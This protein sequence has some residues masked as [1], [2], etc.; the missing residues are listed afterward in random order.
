MKY[1]SLILALA[2]L[3]PVMASA[4]GY[5]MSVIGVPDA[6]AGSLDYDAAT[7]SWTLTCELNDGQLHFPAVRLNTLT[8]P[9][10]AEFTSLCFDYRTT[11]DQASVDLIA[12]KV[13][14]GS[15][16]RVENFPIP[17]VADGEWHTFRADIGEFR[18]Q[19]SFRFLNK[20]GQ[21]QDLRFLALP[22]GGA[23]Q[24]RNIRYDVNEFPFKEITINPGEESIIEAEDFNLAANGKGHSFRHSQLPPM[25]TYY[26][27]PTGPYFPIYAWGSVDFEGGKGA[28]APNFL[29]EQY[30]EL[31]E[32]GFTMTMGTAWPGVDAAF[33][34]D[35]LSINGVQVNLHEG[36]EL[37]MIVKAALGNE[38]EVA[39][40]V[41]SASDRVAGWHIF[42][43]PHRKDFPEMAR[44]VGWVRAVD[45]ERLCYGNL[46]N[47]TTNMAAIGFNN[48]DAYVHTY[49]KEVGTGFLSYDFY[50]V[51]QYINSG[52][53]YIEPD[54][55][56]NLEIVSKLSKYYHTKFWAFAHSVASNCG[57]PG[58]KYPVPEENHMRV[59]VFGNLAYGAQGLQYFTYKCPRPYG[60]Y[61]YTDAPIDID[62][63]RTPVWYM[64]QRINRDIHALTWVFLGAEMLRVG[65]TNAVTPSGC[66]RLSA[67]MLPAGVTSV[68]HGDG[69][70][71][72]CVSMLQ[73]GN[74]LFMM[75][76]N[77]DIH[78]SQTARIET[79]AAMKRVLIDGTT[80][81][82]AAGRQDYEL[83]PGH[84]A[85]FLVSENE[86]EIE[87]LVPARYETSTYRVDAPEVFITA[88]ENASSGHYIAAM[89]DPSWDSY[90]GI[91]PSSGSRIITREQAV[92]NWGSR[93]NY[94]IEVS[95]DVA[96]D[97]SVKYAV[98]FA[99]YSRVASEGLAPGFSYQIED[100]P[101]LNWPKQYAASMILEID[102]VAVS[103]AQDSSGG[104]VLYLGT[105]NSDD[106]GMTPV[107]SDEPEYRNVLLR[108][109]SHRLTVT[110][111]CYPWNFDALRIS[112]TAY[113]GLDFMATD[114]L[115]D[116]P[117]YNLMGIE[118][119]GKLLPGIY[120]RAGKKIIVR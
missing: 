64:V 42:D 70:P 92:D 20:A 93:F 107:Y 67:D 16:T 40:R 104:N 41:V 22:T 111:L 43:E 100:N 61:T 105:R 76:L 30:K 112:P 99:E 102:S 35:G 15:A 47:I 96:V 50:P 63:N 57:K 4:G 94:N 21:F 26:R 24:L 73:N 9:V 91:I 8:E 56:E 27:H 44:K 10:P 59:Q 6:A 25:H 13:F 17:L 34:H 1:K 77:G 84:F 5:S 71:G 28:E 74:N 52:E 82:L 29:H 101:T 97:I 119:R 79:S 62:N 69:N 46:L 11:H 12:Y 78:Q 118:M 31:W 120:V 53:I 116:A 3:A 37:K 83:L 95:A 48:Y 32:C 72:L 54:F 18:T 55:F 117:V 38:S 110:S 108:A 33:I 65:H 85:L 98:P 58:V 51:R 36:T 39:D 88:S 80:E 45:Q 86:P 14:L 66:T 115:T 81:A 90:S 49:M 23:V 103:P 109:G 113:S 19:P 106:D 87:E 114:T 60:G 89:G 68:D 75:V 7:E 2:L